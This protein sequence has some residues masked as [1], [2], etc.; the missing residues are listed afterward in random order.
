MLSPHVERLTTVAYVVQ[1]VFG[2]VIDARSYAV[3]KV[4]EGNPAVV[5][6]SPSNT[7]CSKPEFPN[8]DTPPNVVKLGGKVNSF[9]AV[10]LLKA[11]KFIVVNDDNS[12]KLKVVRLEQSSNAHRP[13]VSIFL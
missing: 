12:S 11:N 6:P 13:M 5:N 10:H 1:D 9:N 4:V 2:I 8:M 7:R 3:L